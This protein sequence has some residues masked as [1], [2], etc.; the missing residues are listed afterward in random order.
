MTRRMIVAGNWKMNLDKS[1]S[2]ELGKAVAGVASSTSDVD[3]AIFPTTIWIS[4]VVDAVGKNTLIIGAQ[5][6]YS[7]SAGAFTGET[8]PD[9][10]ASI[11]GA[12]LVGHSER[13]H[14]IGESDATV[15]RKLQAALSAGL[16]AYLCV[17][18]T[19]EERDAG[20]AEQVVERQ[21]DSALADLDTGAL[22]Q[23]VIA[24]EP[25]WAIGTGR[26]ATPAD[27]QEMSASVRDWLRKSHGESGAAVRV[28]Y[29]GSVSPDNAA[30]IFSQPDV[31]GGLVGGASL[32][33]DS[34]KPIVEA[35]VNSVR[36]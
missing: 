32:K 21:L 9:S 11:A 31:D 20:K 7:E 6:C 27:A 22:G 16:T 15:A 17:G 4:S 23:L 13:R 14:V 19:L 24:Y 2:Q 33:I 25:V 8:S 30:E 3:V 5:D 29:G 10:V 12:C 26:A 18:E 1:S 34:F 36:V 28:L 35:A